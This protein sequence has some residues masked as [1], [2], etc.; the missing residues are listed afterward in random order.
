[1][2]T[3]QNLYEE[4]QAQT[5]D[6]STTSLVLI[7]RAINQG[8]KKFGAI[9]N[10]EWRNTEKTFGVVADQQY[11]QTPEDCIRVR[12]I[13]VTIGGI[14]YPL[15][16]VADEESWRWLNQRSGTSAVPEVFF[17]KDDD[18]FGIYPKPSTT[19]AGAGLI[20]YER[21]MRDMSQA[22]YTTGTISV[23][24]NSIAVVGVGTTFT[25][26]M[27]G[28]FLHINDDSGDGM[29][30]Q[31]SAFTDTTHISLENTYSGLTASTQSYAIG[32]IPDIPEEFHE[33]L[34]DYGC[35]RY[36][37]RRRDSTLARD[38]KS[39]FDQSLSECMADY[40]SK[41]ASQYV[42][43]MKPRQGYVHI[44]RGLSIQ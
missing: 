20:N 4:A 2:L 32:E 23:T 22:D 44:N 11:Y 21:K 1:M 18:Q 27:V 10:R 42:R 26:Q 39:S 13:T 24:N 29:W 12:S 33:A 7:K 38:M 35:Y 6:D 15:T 40:S 34:I 17:V 5:E 31:I 9:L 14:D 25:Q 28:R 3:F 43:P 16:E 37:K 30:Y 36:Y 41:T 19:V 8:A